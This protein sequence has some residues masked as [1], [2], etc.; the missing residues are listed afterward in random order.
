MLSTTE[1]DKAGPG[2]VALHAHYMNAC[3]QNRSN[4]FFAMVRSEY[5]LHDSKTLAFPVG[6]EDIFDLFTLDG[7]EM[8]IL[9]CL[10]L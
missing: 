9:R 7:L 5:F 6:F 3:A 1:L 10:T 4:P 2:C 8:S